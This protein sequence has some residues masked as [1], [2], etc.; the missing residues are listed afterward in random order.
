[1]V[2]LHERPLDMKDA[3]DWMTHIREIFIP[4]EGFTKIMTQSCSI[5]CAPAACLKLLNVAIPNE[6]TIDSIDLAALQVSRAN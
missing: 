4:G 3:T 2:G 1:M 5:N 6:P